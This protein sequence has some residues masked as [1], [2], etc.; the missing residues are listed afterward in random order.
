MRIFVSA[1]LIAAGASSFSGPL[2]YRRDVQPILSEHC[3]HCHGPDAK[4]HEAQLRLD[5]CESQ[6]GAFRTDE[7]VTVIKPGS[8]KESELVARLFPNDEEDVMP[9]KKAKKPLTDSQKETL[10]RCV[11]EGAM[12][13]EH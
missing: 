9:P 1:I 4:S 5:V 11:D 7:G 3:Y 12:W 2:D 8:S 13:G 10:K 6:E